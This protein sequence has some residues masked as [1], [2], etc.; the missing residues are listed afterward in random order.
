MA[1]A[2]GISSL[3]ETPV[4]PSATVVADLGGPGFL[5]ASLEGALEGNS[6][7]SSETGQLTFGIQSLTLSA[8]GRLRVA[9][10][11]SFDLGLGVRGF[12]LVA[13]ASRFT[14]NG[15]QTLLGVGPAASLTMWV[16]LLGPLLLV[17][18]SSA[19]LR[20]PADQLIVTGGP[21]FSLGIWQ[22]SVVAGVSIAWP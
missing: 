22:V 1:L 9:E 15:T 18:R 5:G 10:R 13:T 2:G 12:R 4:T 3:V 14:T 7:V 8:R 11:F 21:T 20:L 19:A 16:R 6:A 17:V